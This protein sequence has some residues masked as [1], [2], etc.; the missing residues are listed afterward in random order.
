[1][2]NRKKYEFCLSYFTGS[3]ALMLI[4]LMKRR[5]RRTGSSEEKKVKFIISYFIFS[6]DLTGDHAVTSEQRDE[7]SSKW[8]ESGR[9]GNV[10]LALLFFCS[11]WRWSN[12][13]VALDYWTERQWNEKT[14]AKSRTRTGPLDVLISP[15]GEVVWK[16]SRRSMKQA[17]S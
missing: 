15:C 2:R 10:P 5:E 13:F 9:K 8:D 3:E 4:F 11:S 16:Q 7:F 12:E 14:W 1:M 17:H 6:H